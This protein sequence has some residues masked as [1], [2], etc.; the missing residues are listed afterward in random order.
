[1][2]MLKGFA[3]GVATP[4]VDDGGFS[5]QQVGAID[6]QLQIALQLRRF[7]VIPKRRQR[8][9]RLSPPLQILPL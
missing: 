1:M 8:R 2:V 4:P 9:H 3:A 7:L 5:A 6:K